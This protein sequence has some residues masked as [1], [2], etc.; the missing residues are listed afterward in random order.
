MTHDAHTDEAERVLLLSLKPRFAEAILS[1]EKT[2]ELRRIGPRAQSPIRALLY[3]SGPQSALIGTC[4]VSGVE[5][6]ICIHELW[7]RHGPQTAI[8]NDEF[9]A[10]F[11]GRQTG[12]AL[13]I[14]E[15]ETLPQPVPLT[16]LR[17]VDGIQPPQSFRYLTTARSEQ[18]LRLA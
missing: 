17:S 4:W 18:M 5:R 7:G 6:D 8:D 16:D 13:I 2:I 3:A 12:S 14:D 1:G 9:Y 10:Y 11:S 15:P